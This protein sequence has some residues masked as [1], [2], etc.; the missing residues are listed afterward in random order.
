MDRSLSWRDRLRLGLPL[1]PISGGIDVKPLADVSE[2][3]VRVTSGRAADYTAGI[4]RTPPDKWSTRTAGAQAAWQAGVAQAAQ[5]NRFVS[6][7]DGKGPKWQRKALSTGAT[8]FGPG[9]SAAREDYQTGFAPYEQV[10]KGLTLPPRGARGDPGN[11]QRVAA[12]A[13][14]L[15]AAR[16]QRR[17]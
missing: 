10:L 17:A 3:W 9:V 2:K 13:A 14:A 6:G 7:V 8:R 4:T 5:E 11:M 16:R 15:N 12:I 1:L